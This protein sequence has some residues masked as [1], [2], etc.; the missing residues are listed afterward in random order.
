MGQIL[1]A[2]K[3]ARAL[4]DF[5]IDHLPRLRGMSVNTIYSYRDCLVM[6]LQYSA[7]Q[8]GVP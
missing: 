3:L 8:N 6:L 1:K 5:F 4:Q 2:N 7:K